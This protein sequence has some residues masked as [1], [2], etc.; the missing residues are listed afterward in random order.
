[1]P[2]VLEDNI[3]QIGPVVNVLTW[4]SIEKKIVGLIPHHGHGICPRV[5]AI[6]AFHVID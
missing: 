4:E 2:F 5:G 3:S 6:K 1:M